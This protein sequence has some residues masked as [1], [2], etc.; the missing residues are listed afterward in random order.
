[1]T[2]LDDQLRQSLASR[3][4]QVDPLTDPLA[5]IEARVSRIRRGRVAAAVI[6]AAAA[7]A[8]VALVVPGVLPDRT[9]T[10]EQPGATPS[11]TAPASVSAW[12]YRGNDIPATTLAAFRTAWQARH[13]GST[14]TPLFG[15]VYEP[16]AQQE[17]VF[18]AGDRMGVVQ[19]A[20]AGPEI[21]YDQPLGTQRELAFV[22]PGDEVARVLVVAAPDSGAITYRDSSS[23]AP[24]ALTALAPGVATGPVAAKHPQPLVSVT[25][26]DGGIDELAPLDVNKTPANLLTWGVR[27]TDAVSPSTLDL[28]TRFAQAFGRDDVFNTAYSPLFVGDTDSGVHYTMGQAWFEGADTAYSVSYATGG[29]NGPAF[30]LGPITPTSPW[31]LAFLF[32]SLPGTSTDLLIVVPRPMTGQ[33]SYSPDATTAFSPV[34]NGRS[35][36]NGIALIDRSKTATNDRLESLEGDGIHVLYRGGVT[37]LLCGLKDCG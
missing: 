35:D 37:P 17:L 28:R 29:T 3:A 34:A 1:M 2:P 12:E 6:G 25:R 13:P 8:A 33:L 27:G 36:L 30:F 16:S 4:A 24:A 18:V 9:A 26:A 15:Q 7:V 21:V 32:D 11:A 14:L 23:D 20:A 5:G 10:R 31:G 19:S 22:M